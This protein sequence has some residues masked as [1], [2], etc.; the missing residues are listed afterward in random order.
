VNAVLED[1]M[2]NRNF[3]QGGESVV[4][5][6]C[7]AGAQGVWVNADYIGDWLQQRSTVTYHA[8]ADAGWLVDIKPFKASTEPL[9]NTIITAAK[10]WNAQFDSSCVASVGADDL[11]KCF[12]GE[13]VHQYVESSF[14]VHAAQYDLFQLPYNG[15]DFP[16]QNSA[17][18]S[19]LQTFRSE[20]I[21]SI[22][23]MQYA[24]SSAW[25][26]PLNHLQ[27]VYVCV[28]GGGV[29]VCLC[30]CV[31]RVIC[32]NLTLCMLS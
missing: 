28:W 7:S 4:A 13:Y 17:A 32:S 31:L 26:V 24:Y 8:F 14:F 12:F 27:C 23:K 18:N 19:W 10:L 21:S 25:Y 15:C 30:V 20:F 5:S 11:W 2:T 6:G 22:N 29:C 3:A 16:P 1:L 9:R